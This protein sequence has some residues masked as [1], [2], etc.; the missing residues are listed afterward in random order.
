MNNWISIDLG[1]SYSVASI[2]SDEKAELVRPICGGLHSNMF[3]P[4]VAFLSEKNDI[5]VCH[6][7]Q[8]WRNI[9]PARFL[10][11][12]K[13]DIHKPLPRLK[14]SYSDI[15][16]EILF[17]IKKSA[18]V[19]NGG[20]EI[21]N[22]IITIPASFDDLDPRTAIIQDCA[23]FV[24]DNV[25]IIKEPEAAAY[26]ADSIL[27]S[28]DSSIS[29]IYDLGGGTF[30]VAMV[31]HE[32]GKCRLLGHSKGIE[33]GG[34]FFDVAIFG[35]FKEK[36]LSQ[37]ANNE[38]DDIEEKAKQADVII[39]M[40]REIKHLLSAN[41]HV[42]Y[43]IPNSAQTFQIDRGE[44]E[45]LIK[46][47]VVRTFDEC[48]DLVNSSGKTWDDIDRILFIGGSTVI[49]SIKELFSK[50]L[51]GH[52]AGDIPI[53]CNKTKEGKVFNPLYAVSLGG[54]YYVLA[55]NREQEY[56]KSQNIS[57]LQDESISDYDKG[58]LSLSENNS[59]PK[60]WFNA[61][62]YFTSAYYDGDQRAHQYLLLIFQKL[63]DAVKVTDNQLVLDTDALIDTFG[64]DVAED[65][66]DVIIHL[67]TSFES[68]GYEWFSE[69]IFELSF[70]CD[71][72]QRQ[73][74]MTG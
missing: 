66:V 33:C 41:E 53:L 46:D 35:Y 2:I 31:Q 13:L 71:Y 37:I 26:Y 57:N 19:M 5:Y 30:D 3:F 72:C 27:Q 17:D 65:I 39:T 28:A 15:I 51:E 16:K 43:P 6:N 68:N 42:E 21:S 34:K 22:A 54:C 8:K 73:K 7:A 11:E 36:Y 9:N 49:P 18:V 24:F 25:Q 10:E 12:F 74:L 58:I 50:Y 14:V 29:L 1:T 59:Q 40:C 62:R 20:I 60:N 48:N 45:T 69:N 4:T 32:N 44:F 70:W 47:M 55:Q 56:S 64:D 52:N 63:V 23:K 61:A 67:E 38:D